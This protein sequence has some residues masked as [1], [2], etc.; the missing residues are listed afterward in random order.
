MTKQ[1]INLKNI[2]KEYKLGQTKI[3]SLKDVS[4][5]IQAGEFISVCGPSGSGKTTLLNIIGCL[6]RAC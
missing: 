3:T 5:D 1:I 4:L 6:D 2:D